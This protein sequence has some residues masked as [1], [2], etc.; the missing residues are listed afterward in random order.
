MAPAIR[1]AA[2]SSSSPSAASRRQVQKSSASAISGPPPSAL[3]SPAIRTS[4]VSLISA[5][6]DFEGMARVQEK[7]ALE[8]DFSSIERLSREH[9]L[10]SP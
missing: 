2:S 8:M 4:A 9:G 3:A 7:Y 5:S 10:G 1:R 6:S